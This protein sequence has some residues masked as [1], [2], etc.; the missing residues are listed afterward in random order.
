MKQP[1]TT[2]PTTSAVF[3]VGPTARDAA[4]VSRRGGPARPLDRHLLDSQQDPTEELYEADAVGS[5]VGSGGSALL[6]ALGVAVPGF[7]AV[8]EQLEL[9]DGPVVDYVAVDGVGHLVLVLRTAGRGPSSVA[10]VLDVLSFSQRRGLVL[11]RLLNVPRLRAD[12]PTRLL[13]LAEAYEP[14]VRRRLSALK[15]CGVELFEVGSLRSAAGERAFVLPLDADPNHAVAQPRA[16][17]EPALADLTDEHRQKVRTIARRLERL[18]DNL[19]VQASRRSVSWF[20][21]PE[22]V[23]R[24]DFPVDSPPRGLIPGRSARTLGAPHDVEL[25]LDEVVASY[26]DRAELNPRVEIAPHRDRGPGP[27]SN[28]LDITGDLAGDD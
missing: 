26:V 25:F 3:P 28:P 17:L 5:V 15:P 14:D 18:D 6:D 11:C 7:E 27:A 22:V 10:A 8:D 12:M 9:D 19:Q 1:H 4:S 16:G 13:V 24:V 2:R 20:L 23:A 21:G